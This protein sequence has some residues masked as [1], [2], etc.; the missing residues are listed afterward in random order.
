MQR[1]VDSLMRCVDCSGA[2]DDSEQASYYLEAAHCIKNINTNKFLQYSRIAI[3]KFCVAARISQAASLAKECAEKLEEDNYYEEAL[4]FY[5]RA[6]ELYFT[7]ETPTQ[8]NQLLIKAS[9]LI[10]LTRNYSQLP[11]AIK[12]YEK[13][14]K[15]FLNTP[16][17]KTNAKELFFKSALCFMANDDM[18]G[19]KRAIQNYQ[20]DDPNF[21]SSRE[22]ELL[23]VRTIS[24]DNY[25][26]G[27]LEAI[28][29][30]S[31]DDFI[32]RV[33][34]FIKMTPFDKV[35]NQLV[36]KIKEVHVPDQAMVAGVVNKLSKLD[37][38]GASEEP[39]KK[40]TVGNTALSREQPQFEDGND[41]E[42]EV[43]QQKKPKK[44]GLPDFT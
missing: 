31:E 32:K 4:Q 21:D 16:L 41:N 36:A 23:M 24:Y 10:V 12:N 37:F 42:E 33:G 7:D 18:V 22:N 15:K 39:T 35:K 43:P 6:A 44:G 9:D 17:I 28:D 30:K 13:V 11:Q 38:T 2:G 25:V 27:M 8:G 29:A 34:A 14:G 26:Q 3:D 1:A 40:T 20:I 19:A 5:E